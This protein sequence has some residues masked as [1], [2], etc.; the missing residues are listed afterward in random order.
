MAGRGGTEMGDLT[1]RPASGTLGGSCGPA[2][3]GLRRGRKVQKA[4]IPAAGL[5]TRFLPATKAQPKEMLPIVDKPTI[6]YVIEEAVEAGIEDILIV[7]GRGKRAIEDHFDKSAELEQWLLSRG[8]RPELVQMVRDISQLADIHFIRQKEPRGLGDAILCAEKHVG[9][10]PFA[11]LL[12]DMIIEGEVPCIGEL[13][14]QF[15]VVG[16][17]VIG[18]RRVGLE[19]VHR[20]G[21]VSPGVWRGRVSRVMDLVEKPARHEAPSDLG[22]IG[23]YV[24][25]PQIFAILKNLEAGVGGE[26]QLTDALRILNQSI[27]T[28]CV[29]VTGNLYD[30]GD[31]MGFLRATVDFALRRPDLGRDF[32]AYLERVVAELGRK[33]FCEEESIQERENMVT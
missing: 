33:E 32:A 19:E 21:I 9:R 11:I 12:G 29:E 5:G 13:A 27:P 17:P 23:R 24:L 15:T 10:D 3:S 31:K 4:V 25:G 1:I 20:Y 26:V 30:V 6:Q 28:Y 2:R 8:D 14:A 22:I 18:V 7:T 16:A